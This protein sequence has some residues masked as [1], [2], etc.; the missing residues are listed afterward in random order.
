MGGAFKIAVGNILQHIATVDN[1]LRLLRLLWHGW[2]YFV[3]KT[4]LPPSGKVLAASVIDAQSKRIGNLE[5]IPENQ[6][7]ASTAATKA[8]RAFCAYAFTCRAVNQLLKRLVG[9]IHRR[10]SVRGGGRGNARLYST[11][12]TG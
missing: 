10:A 8:I 2:E 12:S 1:D 7:S 11:N 5:Q 3:A 6:R 4:A 9:E